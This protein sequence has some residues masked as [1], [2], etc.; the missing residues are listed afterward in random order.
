MKVYKKI[1]MYAVLAALTLGTVGMISFSTD[2]T[3]KEIDGDIITN[4]WADLF[5]TPDGSHDLPIHKD[6]TTKKPQTPS[7]QTS[8]KVGKTKVKS[9][10]KSKSSNKVKVSL[11]KIKGAKKYQVQISKSKNFK[12]VLV[13]KTVKKV[14]FT[15]KSKKLKGK[16]K[17]YVR[18]KAVKYVGKKAYKGKWSKAK[19]IN[20]KK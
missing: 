12:K 14:K 5:T 7:K 9:A 4:P 2:T 10:K 17:L 1:A 3:G 6:E 18:A 19:K 11:K 13:K 16:K 15:I 8:V 20:I